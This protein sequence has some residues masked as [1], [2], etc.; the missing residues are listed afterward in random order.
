MGLGTLHLNENA[1]STSPSVSGFGMAKLIP[2]PGGKK[3]SVKRLEKMLPAHQTYCEPFFGG[4]SLYFHMLDKNSAPKLVI[5]DSNCM[6]MKFYR[7]IGKGHLRQCKN[8]RDK[9]EPEL[10]AKAKALVKR[11]PRGPYTACEFLILQKASFGGKFASGRPSFP[12]V[13]HRGRKIT[14]KVF[15]K[16]PEVE[17]ALKRTKILCGDFAKTMKKYDSKTTL[18]YLD[19]PY[20]D[21]LKGFYADESVT[22]AQ[23][24]AATD[25][26]K[27][28][29][30]LSYS[31]VKAVTDLFC[32]D[33]RYTCSCIRTRHTMTDKG[34]YKDKN[35]LVITNFKVKGLASECRV[36]K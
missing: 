9:T 32:R 4:G 8:L 13:G 26:M 3:Y 1:T 35:E 11:K 15:D 28:H 31:N 20:P 34:G 36:N 25:K 29:V 27:G 6:V 2:Y 14:Q 12:K 19:P 18:H 7:D 30:V 24:K 22:P 21:S 5:S 33:P 17:A 23:V 10:V 16:L